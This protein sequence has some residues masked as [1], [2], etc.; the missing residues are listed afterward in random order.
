LAAN[1]VRAEALVAIFMPNQPHRPENNPAMGTPMAV[2]IGWMP[3]KP[4]T[5]RI[6]TSSTNTAATTLYCRVR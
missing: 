5:S 2:Q 4:I 1:V 6:V 3:V